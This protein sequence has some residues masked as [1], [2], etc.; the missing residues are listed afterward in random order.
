MMNNIIPKRRIIKAQKGTKTK[1]PSGMQLI[2]GNDTV[3]V[4][5]R[6]YMP[7]YIENDLHKPMNQA[8]PVGEFVVTN[9][10]VMRGMRYLGE[11]LKVRKL[12]NMVNLYRQLREA[13][14]GMSRKQS[15]K[16]SDKEVRRLG[17]I[18][19]SGSN[20]A[21]EF[22]YDLFLDPAMQL[23]SKVQSHPILGPLIPF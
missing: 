22:M 17:S 16:W 6:Q 21:A 19:G 9:L 15:M 8:D 14:G 3:Y 23:Y 2:N 13:D 20:N 18:Y 5:Y 1:Q 7:A 10:P 12:R 11:A 4:P